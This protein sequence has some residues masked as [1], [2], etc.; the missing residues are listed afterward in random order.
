MKNVT[1]EVVS[2]GE[3][4][5][6]R[7]RQIV[8]DARR[9]E[10]LLEYDASGLTQQEFA[11]KAGIRYPTLVS[12]LVRR[13][14]EREVAEKSSTKFAQLTL[15]GGIAAREVEVVLG[16]GMTVRGD[17]PARLAAVVKALLAC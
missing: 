6:T 14:R 13:R 5:D 9:E 17:D 15:G 3:K 7:G 10:I 4:R 16:N 12:W 8:P 1:T 2:G 11:R